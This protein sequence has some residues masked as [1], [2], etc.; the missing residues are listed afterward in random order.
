MSYKVITDFIDTQQ[1][2]HLYKVGDSYPIK[3][4]EVDKERV[5][6][7]MKKHDKYKV[8]FLEEVKESKPKT[9]SKSKS[10][11]SSKD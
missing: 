11:P 6:F 10:K 7:L 1:K 3:G 5:E 8:A 4:Y 2:G 9:K